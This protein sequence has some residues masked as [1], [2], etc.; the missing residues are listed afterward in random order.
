MILGLEEI[1]QRYSRLNLVSRFWFYSHRHFTEKPSLI[2]WAIF[3]RFLHKTNMKKFV[4]SSYNKTKILL[5][6][7]CGELIS[8]QRIWYLAWFCLIGYICTYLVKF[9]VMIFLYFLIF[10]T[11]LSNIYL[12]KLIKEATVIPI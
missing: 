3:A 12:V 2:R 7:S 5:I 10:S 11:Y 6:K 4:K 8:S 9:S 1:I